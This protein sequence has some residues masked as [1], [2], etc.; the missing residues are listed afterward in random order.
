MCLAEMQGQ[1]LELLEVSIGTKRHLLQYGILSFLFKA[2]S[3]EPYRSF[4]RV[5]FKG[6]LKGLMCLLEGIL[7][8]KLSSVRCS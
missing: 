7:K 3:R 6:L 4:F 5:L 2:F 1:E 8:R